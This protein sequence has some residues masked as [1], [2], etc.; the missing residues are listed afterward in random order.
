MDGAVLRLSPGGDAHARGKLD[1]AGYAIPDAP[2]LGTI[3]YCVYILH[4]AF[5]LLMHR[6][7]LHGSPEIF[8]AQG[9]GVTLLALILTIGVASLSWRY[10]E[11]PLI[12]RGHRYLYWQA[13]KPGPGT[14]TLPAGGQELCYP[15]KGT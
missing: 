11:R 7:I 9:V 5:N 10:F 2:A 6:L 12:E 13:G 1:C 14:N 15:A 8:D 4:Y 3:S